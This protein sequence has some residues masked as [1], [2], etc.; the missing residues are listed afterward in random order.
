M[1]ALVYDLIDK[2]SNKITRLEVRNPLIGEQSW[3]DLTPMSSK[4]RVHEG[5]VDDRDDNLKLS[6]VLDGEPVTVVVLK[7]TGWDG[8]EGDKGKAS[9]NSCK[10]GCDAAPNWKLV[11]VE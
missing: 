5:S 7:K 11:G 4:L 2:N 1:T 3:E 10:S 9:C 8:V 6:G